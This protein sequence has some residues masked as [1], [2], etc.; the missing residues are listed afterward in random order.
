MHCLPLDYL[1]LYS[2]CVCIWKETAEGNIWVSWLYACLLLVRVAWYRE[3][4]GDIGTIFLRCNLGVE[5][6]IQTLYLPY[7]KQK[8]FFREM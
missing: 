8:Q 6:Y 4:R 1:W 5:F 7:Y 2:R 3:R